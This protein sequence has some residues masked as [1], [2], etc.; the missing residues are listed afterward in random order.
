MKITGALTTTATDVLDEVHDFFTRTFLG[1][2]LGKAIGVA[3]I[4]AF[5]ILATWI[6]HILIRHVVARIVNSVKRAQNVETTQALQISPITSVRIVQRTRT[7]GTVLTNVAN[8]TITVIA[9]LLI[10]NTLNQQILGSLALLSAAVG[11]GLGFGAQNIV[12][13]VLNG[14]FLV[15]EDQIGVG[16]IVEAGVAGMPTTGVIEAVGIR[17]TQVRDVNGTIWYVRNGEILRVGNMSQGWTRVIT[18]V[19]VPYDTD[20][21]TVQQ[22]LLEVAVGLASEAK[23]RTRIVERPE[24]WGIQSISD[25]IVVLRVVAKTGPNARDD[26]AR[27]LNRRLFAAATELGVRVPKLENPILQGFETAS[28][29]NGA[30]PPQTRPT[31]AVGEQP[32]PKRG[33]VLRRKPLLGQVPG[34]E[35]QP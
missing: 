17:I 34:E 30:N 22:K 25:D 18:D 1:E 9:L 6:V 31:P 26:V 27:E 13:D 14:I 4:I 29:V 15:I 21:D 8:V 33:R 10:V 19:A 16:D 12:K 11:A 24:V 28:S 5:A 7:L 23:W 20:I 32:K 3:L 2:I 35:E